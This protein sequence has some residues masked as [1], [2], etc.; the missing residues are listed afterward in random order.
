MVAIKVVPILVG[1]LA[2]CPEFGLGSTF[3]WRDEES[4]FTGK[5]SDARDPHDATAT[6]EVIAAVQHAKSD[7]CLDAPSTVNGSCQAVYFRDK[8][9]FEEV[10]S[11]K[12]T[13]AQTMQECISLQSQ[14]CGSKEEDPCS[15]VREQSCSEMNVPTCNTVTVTVNDQVC[16]NDAT[17]VNETVCNS[18]TEEA[19]QKECHMVEETVTEPQCSTVLEQQC[20]F[21]QTGSMTQKQACSFKSKRVRT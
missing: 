1:A 19:F 11:L 20:R 12:P 6:S 16:N 15:T 7:S 21:L 18:V 8:P 17:A 4:N 9:I 5:A 13:L 14:P 2:L 3:Q 10:C